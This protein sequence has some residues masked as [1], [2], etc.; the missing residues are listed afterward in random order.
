ML[1]PREFNSV[2][3]YFYVEDA[4]AFVDF[5]VNGL[6]STEILRALRAHGC[7]ANAQIRLGNSTAM[8]SE[9]PSSHP[10]MGAANYLYVEDADKAVIPAIRAGATQILP[11]QH[12]DYGGRQ[13]GV[14]THTE[15]F[16][17][18]RSH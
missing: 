2:T 10:E 5:L 11:L 13:S 9:R 12:M 16:G 4:P 18:Y 14:R 7:I 15:I 3:P 6:G 1:L 17:G 8:V